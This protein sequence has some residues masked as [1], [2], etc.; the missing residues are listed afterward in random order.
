MSIAAFWGWLR[1]ARAMR[2]AATPIL[3]LSLLFGPSGPIAAQTAIALPR[4]TDDASKPA[5][6]NVAITA[7]QR[8]RKL[9]IPSGKSMV[10]D[11]PSDASEVFVGN[12]Q[13]ANA[14]VR[15][16][17]RLYVMAVA[18]G[19]TT[20]FALDKAGQQIATLELV[21]VGR[22]L[23]DLKS[24]LDAAIPGNEI[25]IQG[26]ND[27]V[28]LTGS[29]ASAVD[30]QRA[31][32]IAS[33][34]VGYTPVGASSGASSS[35]G[36]S[37][38]VNF[39]S[40]IVVNGNLIN[41]LVIRGQE[42]VTLKV[43]VVEVQRDIVKQLGIAASG[44]F[45][46]TSVFENAAPSLS[47]VPAGY[48]SPTSSGFLTGGSAP[49]I[50]GKFG[51]LQAALQAYERNGVARVLAEPTVT[52]ISG[53]SAKF[54]AGGSI[55]VSSSSSIDPKTGICT[56]STILQD[57]GV[58]LNFTPTVLSEGRIS[59]HIAT[60]VTEPDGLNA[61]AYACSNQIG[62]RTR[63]NT[64]TVELPSGGSLVSAGLIQQVS[65]QAIA[66]APGLMNLPI[67]GSLFRSRD[68]QRQES[69][70]MIIVTPYLVKALRPDQV[71]KPDDGFA[72]ATDPQSWFLGRMNKIYSTANNPELIKNYKGH[73]GF[74]TD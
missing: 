71:T 47:S 44:T 39:S 28:I 4:V 74:I 49:A 62:F 26:I 20:I 68:Y 16:A 8:T 41:S 5:P 15:S 25:T 64:T 56:V 65:K 58:T 34:Y 73:V 43:T 53:E 31:F 72:D 36:G 60:E 50:S 17:R 21:V 27:T 11:L 9:T 42:Q 70:L 30:A 67:L 57:Y 10:V 12:P 37:S 48:M 66:G 32:D 33:A 59:L 51:S 40:P 19:Q 24:I 18:N 6:S 29:V 55:P 13:V 61:V 35:G 22:D 63:K 7:G 23:S 54:T 46:S 45:G 38:S 1:A 2:R 3:G 52:A 69:E 14:V